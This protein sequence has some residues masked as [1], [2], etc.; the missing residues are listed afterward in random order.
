MSLPEQL[1]GLIS[2]PSSLLLFG[3]T[4]QFGLVLRQQL[5]SASLLLPE[6]IAA[7]FL[8]PGKL[9][10]LILQCRPKVI[11]NAAAYTSVDQAEMEPELAYQINA[12]TVAVL[13]ES[14]KK[15]GA[16][17]V[18]IS[19]DYVFDGSGSRPWQE[20]DLPAPVNIYGFSKWLGEK[21]I[22]ASGC[23]HL[24]L[25]TSWLHSP[26][27]NNFLKNMLQL[28]TESSY[29]SIVCDQI[30]APTSATLLA[31][32]S[33]NAVVQ[34]LKNPLLGGLYH[35]VAAGE[36]SWYNYARF[37]FKEANDIGII[38]TMPTLIPVKSCDYS[39]VALRPLNSRLN[40]ELFRQMFCYEFPSWEDGV[41]ETL[42]YLASR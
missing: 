9:E 30:G 18:H 2:N 13:A 22:L 35:V 25:R 26:H 19:T 17:L 5:E 38:N 40:N 29:L 4:G 11:I 36:V 10:D 3:S 27:R 34:T 16:L 12:L 41:R 32:A 24:I 14:A 37:I 20:N 23:Q 8:Q 15:V 21:A 6:R 31:D 28:G 7:D 33:L 42:L 1:H 39:K